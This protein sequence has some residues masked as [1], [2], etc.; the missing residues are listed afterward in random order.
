MVILYMNDCY[1]N[2]YDNYLKFNQTVIGDIIKRVDDLQ[3]VACLSSDEQENMA[4]QVKTVEEEYRIKTRL[5]ALVCQEDP[6]EE[7]KK[8]DDD[9]NKDGDNGKGDEKMEDDKKDGD[10]KKEDNEKNDVDDKKDGDKEKKI[11]AEKE[12]ETNGRESENDNEEE[13]EDE[14][15]V[16]LFVDLSGFRWTAANALG[17]MTM[18]NTEEPYSAHDGNGCPNNHAHIMRTDSVEMME[19]TM[20]QPKT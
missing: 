6:F 15:E 19:T 7:E 10:T 17:S 13:E 11:D 12:K 14:T 2:V 4:F 5:N 8:D 3:K 9:N 16:D 1:N 20:L 18:I